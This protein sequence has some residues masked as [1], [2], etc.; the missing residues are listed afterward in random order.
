MQEELVEVRFAAKRRAEIWHLVVALWVRS[1]QSQGGKLLQA[2][3]TFLLCLP[4]SGYKGFWVYI[5][6]YSWLLTASEG[7]GECEKH[8][9]HTFCTITT[10]GGNPNDKLQI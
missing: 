4:E 8:Q 10:V 5:P 9:T 1:K 7:I 2:M 3:W 6:R